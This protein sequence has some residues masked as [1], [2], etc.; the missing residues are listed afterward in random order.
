[1][2]A[3]QQLYQQQLQALHLT[4]TASIS[5]DSNLRHPAE[6]AIKNLRSIPNSTVLLLQIAKEAAVDLPIR[7]A[8]VIH[9]KNI[10]DVRTDCFFTLFRSF[11][12]PLFFLS[13]D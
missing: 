4:L 10:A 9:L 6:A 3:Q 2:D 7:Q 12:L 1:M 13:L 8:A 11:F 5:A